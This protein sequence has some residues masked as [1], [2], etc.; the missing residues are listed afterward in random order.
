MTGGWL[1]S[2]THHPVLLGYGLGERW[3][4]IEAVIGT[5]Q[6]GSSRR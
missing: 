5:Y 6:K 2:G 3:P 1:A 4:E